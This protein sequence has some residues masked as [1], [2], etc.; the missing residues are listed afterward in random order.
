MKYRILG[1]TG[2]SVS[3][4]GFGA[5]AIGG[6]SYGPTRDEDSLEAL[7][8]AWEHGVN[9]FDT[10]DTYGEGHSEELIGRFLRGKRQKAVI[11]TKVGWDF[12]HGGSK[13]NFDPDY[14]RFACG[15]SLKRLQTDWIDLYQLHN[16]RLEQMESGEIFQILDELKG[17]GKIRFYGV[18]VHTPREA[19]AVIRSG[20]ADAIQLIFNLIDQRPVDEVFPEAREKKIGIIAREPLACGL[21]TG[22]YGADSRFSKDDHR[23]RW[24]REKLAIDLQKIDRLKSVLPVSRVSLVQ[25]ALEFILNFEAVSVVIPGAKT[26]GQVLEHVKASEDPRLRAQEIALV[27]ELYQREE[28]FHTGFYRN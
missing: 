24:P 21:L 5:W 11:A 4:I 18:S 10:A 2:L 25:S 20:K 14:I 17:E 7:A 1:R 15:E 12:Y 26:K 23:N 27:R 22:K 19:L 3:E 6:M 13:K 16:P 28:I 9:F 8:T